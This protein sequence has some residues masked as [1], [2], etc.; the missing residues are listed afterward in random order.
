MVNKEWGC[1]WWW[2]WTPVMRWD[3]SYEKWDGVNRVGHEGYR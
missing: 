1:A 3:G 2:S